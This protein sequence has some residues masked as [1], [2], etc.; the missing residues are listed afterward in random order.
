GAAQEQGAASVAFDGAL[1]DERDIERATEVGVEADAAALAVDED[2]GADGQR[3]VGGAEAKGV[4][5]TA[6]EDDAA[7]AAQGLA[8]AVEADVAVAARGTADH[9]GAAQGHVADDAHAKVIAA[10]RVEDAA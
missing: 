10:G 7:A 1:V 2:A 9:D 6:A 5:D 4:G 8:A 3:R